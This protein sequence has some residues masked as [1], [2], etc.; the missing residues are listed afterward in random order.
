MIP[1]LHIEVAVIWDTG[2]AGTQRKQDHFW[3]GVGLPVLGLSPKM[4]V[5]FPTHEGF[6]VGVSCDLDRFS[7]LERRGWGGRK[8]LKTVHKLPISLV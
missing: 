7:N 2:I 5:I 1:G 4:E 8:G 6:G 3:G